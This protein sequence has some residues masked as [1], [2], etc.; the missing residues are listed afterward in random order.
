MLKLKKK[1]GER[2]DQNLYDINKRTKINKRK[3]ERI[4]GGAHT[5]SSNSFNDQWHNNVIIMGI[6]QY[7]G[8]KV[9]NLQF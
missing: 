7:G 5:F 2:N 4:A 8:T 3:L 9:V 6:H 1:K